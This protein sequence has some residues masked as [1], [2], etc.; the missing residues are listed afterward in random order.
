M[1]EAQSQPAHTTTPALARPAT[2]R[3][4]LGG[5]LGRRLDA[6]TEQ[7]LLPVAQS[8]PRILEMFRERDL[9]P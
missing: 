7:W 1:N 6:V 4:D 2:I 3:F 5:E 8:N 9:K